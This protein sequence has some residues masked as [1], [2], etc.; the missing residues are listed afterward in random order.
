MGRIPRMAVKGERAICHAISRT[1][2]ST[3]G[4]T[5]ILLILGGCAPPPS[6]TVTVTAQPLEIH[7]GESSAVEGAARINIGMAPAPVGP[8]TFTAPLGTIVS[9]VNTDNA[10]N[11]PSTFSAPVVDRETVVT[12]TATHSG[13]SGTVDI[14]VHPPV[15]VCQFPDSA[16]GQN[17]PTDIVT[18]SPVVKQKPSGEWQWIYTLTE[19][20]GHAGG[21]RT[22][23]VTFDAPSELTS[24]SGVVLPAAGLSLIF[25]IA[26]PTAPFTVTVDSDAKP[27]GTANWDIIDNPPN[28]R[29]AVCTTTGPK[30]P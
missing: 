19:G 3:V 14:T 28:I 23:S 16:G 6:A 25:A 20:N 9:P 11:A 30:A 2:R 13:S 1:A 21:I 8:M 29:H 18:I 5:L 7:S 27:G 15:G 22:A 17:D 26:N 12:V 10:G 24:D 4:L